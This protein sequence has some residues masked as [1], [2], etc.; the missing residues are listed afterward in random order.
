M[1]EKE[2]E[3]KEV[4][5]EKEEKK[6]K[7]EKEE[8]EE[9]DMIPVKQEN[10]KKVEIKDSSILIEPEKETELNSQK[11]QKRKDRLFLIEL[12]IIFVVWIFLLYFVMENNK[13]PPKKIKTSK[14]Y[15]VK[16]PKKHYS[17]P[18]PKKK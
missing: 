12:I 1:E 7:K 17:K 9:K 3:E 14:H 15:K 6:E 4:K 10:S 5:E 2:K 8:K 11:E 13:L 18:K 16:K